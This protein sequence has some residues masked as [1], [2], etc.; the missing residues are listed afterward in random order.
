MLRDLYYVG[1]VVYKGEVYAGRH[2]PIID[3][4]LF[5]R[6]QEVLAFRSKDGQRDRVLQHYLKGSLFCD[7]CE[8][9]ERTSRLIY[10]EATNRFGTRAGTSSAADARTAFATCSIYLRTRWN[11]RSLTTT[12]L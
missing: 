7:R 12:R 2:E 9:Q 11:E 1:C 4:V 5:D 3:Q 6:V 10:T 8:R